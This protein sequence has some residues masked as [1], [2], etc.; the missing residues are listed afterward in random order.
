MEKRVIGDVCKYRRV[1]CYCVNGQLGVGVPVPLGLGQALAQ[2][3]G[4]SD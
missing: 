3:D 4:E 1:E 2:N